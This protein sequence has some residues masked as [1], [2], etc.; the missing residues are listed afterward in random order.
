M[1][2]ILW[3]CSW[4]C[5]ILIGMYMGAFSDPWAYI[6]LNYRTFIFCRDLAKVAISVKPAET[7]YDGR[8]KSLHSN[9]VLL[10]VGEKCQV[11]FS[12]SSATLFNYNSADFCAQVKYSG[13]ASIQ[14]WIY[15]FGRKKK[16]T[17]EAEDWVTSYKCTRG[18][19]KV[20]TV[21]HFR[22]PEGAENLFFMFL[23]PFQ[24]IKPVFASKW[25]CRVRAIH[26]WMI[27]GGGKIWS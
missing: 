10:I 25:S 19:S 12:C 21:G 5:F 2:F 26:I 24:L 16:N 23:H 22:L 4:N 27:W 13:W 17:E 3:Q 6:L 20:R 9:K 7:A 18:F 1:K 14:I 15:V 8:F 11:C